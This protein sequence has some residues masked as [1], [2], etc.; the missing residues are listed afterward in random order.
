M[1]TFT[2][3]R[4]EGDWAVLEAAEAHTLR[5][6]RSWLPKDAR[7][8]AVLQVVVAPESPGASSVSFGLDPTTEERRRQDAQRLRDSLRKGPKGDLAL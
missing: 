7:E 8:G 4:F 3:D 2:I 5:V 1:G 6:P